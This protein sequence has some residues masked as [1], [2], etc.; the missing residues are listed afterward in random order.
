MKNRVFFVAAICALLAWLP[1]VLLR[2]YWEHLIAT[3][4]GAEHGEVSGPVLYFLPKLF[5]AAAVV[6]VAAASTAAAFA[7]HNAQAKSD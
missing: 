4:P 1:Y 6:T 2:L 5:V 7:L 3:V